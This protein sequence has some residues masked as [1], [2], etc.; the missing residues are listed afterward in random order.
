MQLN[1]D[2]QGFDIVEWLSALMQSVFISQAFGE[3]HANFKNDQICVSS[4]ALT[5]HVTDSGLDIYRGPL[6]IQKGCLTS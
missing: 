5:S 1:A 4:A 2:A 3:L 6:C